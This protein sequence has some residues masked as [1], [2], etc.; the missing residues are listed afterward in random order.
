MSVISHSHVS[1][2]LIKKLFHLLKYESVQI[3]TW[4]AEHISEIRF[5]MRNRLH[6][7]CGTWLMWGVWGWVMTQGQRL[8]RCWWS[9]V[10]RRFVPTITA[11]DFHKTYKH[12]CSLSSGKQSVDYYSVFVMGTS[13]WKLPLLFF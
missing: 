1:E 13:P 4:T 9:N 3:I 7:C 10:D 6:M 5:L 11:Y 8:P 12:T 2:V